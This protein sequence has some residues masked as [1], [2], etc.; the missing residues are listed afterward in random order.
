MRH[1]KK[2][3]A[4]ATSDHVLQIRHSKGTD[5]VRIDGKRA[6]RDPEKKANGTIFNFSYVIFHFSCFGML[7]FRTF[8]AKF[9]LSTLCCIIW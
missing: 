1:S 5:D 3:P 8:A 9:V 6:A 2:L 7:F 4:N